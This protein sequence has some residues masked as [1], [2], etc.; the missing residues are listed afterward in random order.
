MLVLQ[1]AMYEGVRCE[2]PDGRTIRVSLQRVKGAGV[3]R[4]GF[5]GPRDVRFVREELTGVART[6]HALR[7]R[8]EGGV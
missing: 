7:E 8:E 2:L 5:E 1:L 3:V 4:I 6:R